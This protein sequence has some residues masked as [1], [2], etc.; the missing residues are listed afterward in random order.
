MAL[1][2][3]G[4]KDAGAGLMFAAIGGFADVVA[5]LHYPIGTAFRMGPGFFPLIVGTILVLL[6][7]ILLVR[8]VVIEG[9]GI[10]RIRI[11]PLVG[12]MISV[13]AFAATV[14]YF[15]IVIAACILV[16]VSR[17]GG[18][19]YSWLK[20][21]VLSAVLTALSVGIFVYGLSMPFHL[22]PRW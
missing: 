1:K 21:L 12:I 13:V 3:R 16:M 19:S 4:T 20:S 8:S 15:G 17:T 11:R 22:W 18:W 14:D 2:I 9:S 10:D 6:G 5:V 7:A